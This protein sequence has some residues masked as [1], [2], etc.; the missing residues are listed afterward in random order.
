MGLNFMWV[1]SSGVYPTIYFI[2]NRLV[3]LFNPLK[4]LYANSILQDVTGSNR[5]QSSSGVVKLQQPFQTTS[6][7][8]S[9]CILVKKN[10]YLN[11]MYLLHRNTQRLDI[12]DSNTPCFK[13]TRMW[14]RGTVR[15]H[16][17]AVVR[18]LIQM[19]NG[20]AVDNKGLWR[21]F[22]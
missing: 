5:R 3:I 18:G 16:T 7:Q 6:E 8:C 9:K 1:L 14:H 20:Q 19:V 17:W 22:Q 13:I 10:K 15:F 12:D 21:E 4:R 11:R 2:V